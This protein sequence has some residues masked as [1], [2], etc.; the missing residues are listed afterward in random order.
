MIQL[1]QRGGSERSI[2][3]ELNISRNTLRKY[4]AALKATPYAYKD[5]LAMDDAAL[6]EIIYP[7]TGQAQPDSV[8]TD[9][10]RLAAFEAL[11]A[12]F[13][14][15]LDRTGVTKQLLWKDYLLKHPDGYRY[16]QFCERLRRYQKNTDVSLHIAYKPGDTLMIDF[17]GDK[18]SYVDRETG[19][20]IDCPVL[21][22]V[23]PFSGYSYVEALPNATLPQLVKALNNCL[24]FFGG[25]PLN[26]ITDNMRQM[27]TKACR[28]EPVFTDMILSWAQHNNIHLKAARV[29]TPR[30]KPHV[31]NEVKITYSRIY[32]PLRDQV[33]HSLGEL[34]SAII[35]LLK[36]HHKQPFQKKESNRLDLFTSAEQVLL[37]SLPSQPYV[38]KY[39]TESKVQR[40]YCVILGEDRHFYSVP[41]HLVGK[42]LRIVY[43][44]DIVEIFHGHQRIATHPRNY[45]RY[46][47][48]ITPAHMPDAHRSYHEQMG[49]DKDYFLKQGSKIGPYTSQYMERMMDSKPHKEQAY[50]GCMGILRL[51]ATHSAQ[52]TETACKLALK[53]SSTSYRTVANI[54]INNR[55]LMLTDEQPSLFRLPL[56]DNLRGSEAYN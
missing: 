36:R 52:R 15:E 37:Q 53:S 2:A 45:K 7:G 3:K 50:L 34:N 40:N 47:Y 39:A 20:R 12:H 31:E 23:L 26:L 28:Y 30:D 38:M 6:S 14:K 29:R 48:S 55:D 51:A 13:L 22:C 24:R 44:T 4:G 43:D 35:R 56:H 18:L 9:D 10:P 19:E 42:K 46:D 27:V 5:L 1:L 54:L 41:Y 17:A 25:A 16:T 21:V 11:R 32:A 8:A 49:W 33:Y